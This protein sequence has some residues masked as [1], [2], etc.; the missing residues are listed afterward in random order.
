MVE[1]GLHLYGK[2]I[3]IEAVGSSWGPMMLTK[4]CSIRFPLYLMKGEVIEIEGEYY[5]IPEPV[6]CDTP[7]DLAV[8][9][10]EKGV[11]ATP[12]SRAIR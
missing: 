5:T 1:G 3:Y 10:Y 6:A 11:K 4:A 7:K 2:V 9:L 8:F 12:A